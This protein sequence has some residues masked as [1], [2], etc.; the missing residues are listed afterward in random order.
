MLISLIL[1]I[2]F[3]IDE[4]EGG[5]GA[6]EEFYT[7]EEGLENLTDE[8]R[9]N[10]QRLEGLIQTSAPEANG[11]GLKEGLLPFPCQHPFPFEFH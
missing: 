9:A 6:G 3:F 11:G 2:Y 4:W 10:L 5:I 8:G 7:G 1:S